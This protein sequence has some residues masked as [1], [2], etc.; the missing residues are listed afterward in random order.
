MNDL[1]PTR[2]LVTTGATQESIDDVRYLGNRSSGKLG[3]LIA[4]SAA[5]KGY[6]VSLLH[7]IQSISP[8]LHPRIHSTPFTST[9]DLR[10]KLDEHWP[11]HEILIMAAAVSDY[12]PRGGQLHGKIKRGDELNIPLSPTKDIV[13]SLAQHKR[14]DQRIIAFALEEPEKLDVAAREKLQRKHVDAIVANP[15]ETMNSSN[16]QWTIYLKDGRTLSQPGICTKAAFARWLTDNL[17]A[18]TSATPCT[19]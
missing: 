6:E 3:C 9:R 1:I 12:T 15:L 11:S 13:A 18:I 2:I 16:I 5:I 8:S 7:G 14:E 4:L 19:P 10:A 17:D